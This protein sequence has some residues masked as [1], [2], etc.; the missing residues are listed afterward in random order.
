MYPSRWKGKVHNYILTVVVNLKDSER[1][2]QV[3]F[4]A[5]ITSKTVY[6]V[7]LNGSSILQELINL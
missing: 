5:L 2:K 6:A 7:Q 1:M 4:D 3:L